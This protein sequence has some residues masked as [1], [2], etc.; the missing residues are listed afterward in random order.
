MQ[1]SSFTFDV[2]LQD[3]QNNAT[4]AQLIGIAK[5]KDGAKLHCNWSD[6][7]SVNASASQT[8]PDQYMIT[9]NRGLLKAIFENSFK[10]AGLCSKHFPVVAEDRYQ[11]AR[12]V[13]GV[14]SEM[15]FWHEYAHL[16]RGHLRYLKSQGI[17]IARLYERTTEQES[18]IWPKTDLHLKRFIE[19]DADIWG[20]VLLFGRTVA[21]MKAPEGKLS[22]RLWMLG[23]V[24]GIRVMYESIYDPSEEWGSRESDHPHSL[25]RALIAITHGVTRPSRDISEHESAEWIATAKEA[26]EFYEVQGSM[27]PTPLEE[28]LHFMN[29]EILFWQEREHDL[30]A[31][32]NWVPQAP[33]RYRILGYFSGL[34]AHMRQWFWRKGLVN[35]KE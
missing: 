29:T 21:C 5:F 33:L 18:N 3:V 26:F 8:A 13:A 27:A 6:S 20:A 16:Y 34:P 30:V 31:F 10:A 28:V 7:E 22:K 2:Y 15:V 35:T 9:V 4:S 25:V 12:L 24:I 1:R 14:A 32:Q 19:I 11:F 23:F 17:N